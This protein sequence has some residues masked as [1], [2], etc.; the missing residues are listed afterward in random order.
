MII[1]K[2]YTIIINQSHCYYC[3]DGMD[4]CKMFK[5]VGGCKRSITAMLKA[6]EE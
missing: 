6:Q 4:N 2:G 3:I 5:T 1:Y